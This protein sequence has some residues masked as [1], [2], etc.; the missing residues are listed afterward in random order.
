MS[1][2]TDRLDQ[3]L[4]D[5]AETVAAID[6]SEDE[7]AAALLH[8]DDFGELARDAADA[9]ADH[10]PDDLLEA[11]AFDDTP[12]SIPLA[13]VSGNRDRVR[14]L[15][16]LV[17][18]AK[19]SGVSGDEPPTDE[20]ALE[21]TAT[22]LH[23]SLSD[24]SEVDETAQP[25]PETDAEPDSTGDAD[26]THSTDDWSGGEVI[27]EAAESALEGVRTDVQELASE[28]GPDD[29]EANDDGDRDESEE[30]SDDGLLDDADGPFG[31]GDDGSSDRATRVSTMPSRRPDMDAVR[32]QS[33]MRD[34][35][36]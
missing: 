11:L 1:E 24:R 14:D 19:L 21:E 8:T 7:T 20:G 28:I 27:R 4:D 33:T 36:R 18:L 13:I 26:E 10:E 23:E 25:E 16:A 22:H 17:S 31:D 12:R 34:R 29:D 35:S 32:R 5:A 15:R 6:E 30:A 2:L 3:L 9:L